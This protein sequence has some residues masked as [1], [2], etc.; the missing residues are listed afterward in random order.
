MTPYV[1]EWDPAGGLRGHLTDIVMI[2]KIGQS[3]L[4]ISYVSTQSQIGWYVDALGLIQ[5]TAES[6]PVITDIG[7]IASFII[8][9]ICIK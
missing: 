9:L 6:G 3:H 8:I 2:Q 1:H 7:Q 4:T 5:P